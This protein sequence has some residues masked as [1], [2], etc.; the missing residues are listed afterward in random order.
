MTRKEKIE[1]LEKNIQGC[2]KILDDEDEKI[3]A[4]TIAAP[5]GKLEFCLVHL[6][7]FFERNKKVLETEIMMNEML[8]KK[9]EDA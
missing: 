8:N 7:D 3:N 1:A 6:I 5:F 9:E 2:Q 4:V